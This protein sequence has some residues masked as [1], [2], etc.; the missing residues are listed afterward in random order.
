[1]FSER[2][3]F[4]LRPNR[5]SEAIAARRAGG[6]PLLD[7]TLSNPTRAGLAATVDPLA[8]LANPEGRVYDPRPLGLERAREAAQFFDRVTA[9]GVAQFI[10]RAMR[11]GERAVHAGAPPGGTRA[12]AAAAHRARTLGAVK[13]DS[14][15]SAG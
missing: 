12:E 4:D 15:T 2:T 8:E 7:L 13:G 1:M 3:R 9:G 5:L 6:A 11:K 10:E 14:A